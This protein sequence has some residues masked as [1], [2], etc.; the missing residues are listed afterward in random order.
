MVRIPK[1]STHIWYS[2]SGDSGL[3]IPNTRTW[4]PDGMDTEYIIH[5]WPVLCGCILFDLVGTHSHQ[6][7]I[8]MRRAALLAWTKPFTRPSRPYNFGI[9]L[10]I[11]PKLFLFSMSSFYVFPFAASCQLH[12][13]WDVFQNSMGCHSQSIEFWG[14][15]HRVL[16]KNKCFS[17]SLP[18]R[19]GLGVGSV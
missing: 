9:K 13:L 14:I 15:K 6:A 4:N 12:P 3:Q 1:T 2:E 10:Y 16:S 5:V 17:H 19:E 11:I 18:F 7:H 8:R